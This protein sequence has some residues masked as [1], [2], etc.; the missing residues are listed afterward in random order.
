MDLNVP[1]RLDGITVIYVAIT[2][3]TA[4]S[5]NTKITR[6]FTG[7]SPF[8]RT[9]AALNSTL[10]YPVRG[11]VLNPNGYKTR[12]SFFRHSLTCTQFIAI[13]AVA[14]YI[15]HLSDS[16]YISQPSIP[17]STAYYIQASINTK[18]PV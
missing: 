16:L 5:Q 10:P 11:I 9:S 3:F 1:F 17:P 14:Y 18:L 13:S 12:A 6:P 7:I 4:R 2:S 8:L 15:N